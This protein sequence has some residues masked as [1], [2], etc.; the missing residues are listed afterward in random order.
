[1]A[2]YVFDLAALAHRPAELEQVAVCGSRT[3]GLTIE[4]EDN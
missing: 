2:A 4:H 1:V 3:A